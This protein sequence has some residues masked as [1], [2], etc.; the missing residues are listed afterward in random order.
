MILAIIHE[1][2]ALIALSLFTAAVASWAVIIWAL[3]S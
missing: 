3:L 1:L 2:A